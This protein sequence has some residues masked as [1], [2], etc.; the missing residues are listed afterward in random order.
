LIT[1][2]FF[3]LSFFSFSSSALN[4]F[5]LATTMASPMVPPVGRGIT[6]LP[7]RVKPSASVVGAHVKQRITSSSPF[8]KK[9]AA[10]PFGTLG[11]FRAW[12][13]GLLHSKHSLDD[14]STF[15]PR[16]SAAT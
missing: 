4:L 7:T 2:C 15:A 16:Q 5:T 1:S 8:C 3:F 12:W 14:C 11:Q 10:L 9:F 6:D 13:P